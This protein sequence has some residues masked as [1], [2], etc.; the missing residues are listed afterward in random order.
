[1]CIHNLLQLAHVH[2]QESHRWQ[3]IRS[4]NRAQWQWIPS[5][6]T[7]SLTLAVTTGG[8]GYKS[9]WIMY[10]ARLGPRLMCWCPASLW[11]SG[12]KDSIIFLFITGLNRTL[13]C[14]LSPTHDHMNDLLNLT[15]ICS[16]FTSI[17]CEMFV[18]QR[19]SSILYLADRA[20]RSPEC[21]LIWGLRLQVDYR[22]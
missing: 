2:Q 1:M 17:C 18:I 3:H 7:M 6:C 15:T 16:H 5:V 11:R 12:W 8:K 13:N 14:Y 19:N 10:Q 21:C 20:L 4:L 22:S 9:R